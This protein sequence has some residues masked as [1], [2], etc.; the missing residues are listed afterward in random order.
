MSQIRAAA[1]AALVALALTAGCNAGD[2]TD[3]AGDTSSLT[4]RSPAGRVTPALDSIAVLG[5]SGATGTMSDVHDVGRDAHEN[6][7]ATGENPAVQSIYWRLLQ[8][9]PAMRGHN[10]DEAVNGTKVD[11]LDGQLLTL[12]AEAD[13]LPDVLLVQSIDNDMRCDGTDPQN[14]GPYGAALDEAISQMQTAIPGVQVFLV[15]QWATVAGWTTWAAHRQDLVTDNTGTG[16]C[17]VFDASGAVRPAGVQSM[18]EIVDTYWRTVVQVCSKHP[19]CYTDGGAEQAFTV[20][21]RDLAADG[22]HLSIA[23][24][25]KFA[26][27]AWRTLP[28]QITQRP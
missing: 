15:S 6:S 23:G 10:Y 16:P 5:H 28:P 7:W 22:N 26:A 24:H 25:H 14:Y 18:Q 8:T 21:D 9:H 4:S 2:S 11:A 27:I 1:A 20:T 17:G 19:G 13:P 12:L 3:R